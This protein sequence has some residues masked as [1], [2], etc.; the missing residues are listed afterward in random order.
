MMPTPERLSDGVYRIYYAGRDKDN[1]SHV[2]LAGVDLD[3]LTLLA[4]TEEPYLSPGP[5]GRFDDGG[6]IPSCKIDK[7]LYYVG[8]KPGGNTR[9]QLLFGLYGIR[10]QGP[11]IHSA[12]GIATAPWIEETT[13]KFYFV[14]GIDW[15]DKDTPRYDIKI[16]ADDNESHITAISLQG[17]EIAL[18]RP[19]VIKDGDLWRMWFCSKTR[20]APYRGQYAESPDGINWE[21]KPYPFPEE[22]LAYPIVIKHK[23]KEIMLYNKNKGEDGIYVAV[24]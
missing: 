18:A 9:F 13:G 17:D 4:Q 10:R 11:L 22:Y 20:E 21:R 12:V 8:I 24:I 16:R 5:L 14:D 2:G 1:R 7:T 23:D 3:T 19:Y 6:V 15:L